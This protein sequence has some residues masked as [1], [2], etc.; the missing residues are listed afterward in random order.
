MVALLTVGVSYM[1]AHIKCEARFRKFWDRDLQ[2]RL[3][4]G[5]SIYSSLQRS[6]GHHIVNTHLR[7]LE[8]E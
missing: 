6:G 4:A 8:R 1:G 2:E 5:V 7:G 3:R